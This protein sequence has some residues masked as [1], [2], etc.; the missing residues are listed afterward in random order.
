MTKLA[1][2]YCGIGLRL[3]T[4]ISA[5]ISASWIEG[6][7]VFKATATLLPLLVVSFVVALD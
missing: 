5:L 1:L 4:A 3:H 2:K 6:Y 7:V